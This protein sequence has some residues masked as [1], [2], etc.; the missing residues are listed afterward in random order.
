MIFF[1]LFESFVVQKIKLSRYQKLRRV[2]FP[3]K[4]GILRDYRCPQLIR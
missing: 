1:V 2:F 3:D 4:C